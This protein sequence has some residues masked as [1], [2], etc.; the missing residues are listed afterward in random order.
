MVHFLSSEQ[1]SCL[2]FALLLPASVM[3]QAST[4]Y[5]TLVYHEP[6]PAFQLWRTMPGISDTTGNPSPVGGLLHNIEVRLH[7]SAVNQGDSPMLSNRIEISV[8][9]RAA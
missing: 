2:L 1:L 8:I 6:R 4:R 3:C 7:W 9:S 5:E